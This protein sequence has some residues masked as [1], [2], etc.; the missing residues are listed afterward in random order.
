MPE[1]NT[2]VPDVV[3]QEVPGEISLAFI[4]T[5]CP[6]K[7]NGCHSK[8]TW[9]PAAGEPLTDEEFR[10]WLERYGGLIT[11]VVFFGGEWSPTHLCRKL[12]IAREYGLKTCLYS[13]CDRLSGKIRSRLDF[14][15]LGAWRQEL[16][17]LDSPVTNQQFIHL[18]S[19]QVMNFL[20]QG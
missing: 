4:V 10:H 8:D 14:M 20:F 9:D 5:G 1:F 11:C 7:C 15:K 6:L 19:G 18:S 2:I 16:G 17:G 13:G 12:D 3:F